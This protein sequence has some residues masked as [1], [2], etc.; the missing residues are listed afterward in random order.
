MNS[1]SAGWVRGL[2]NLHAWSRLSEPPPSRECLPHRA[3]LWDPPAAGTKSSKQ[4]GTGGQEASVL[5]P[6]CLQ[7]AVLKAFHEGVK[8]ISLWGNEA[9]HCTDLPEIAVPLPVTKSTPAQGSPG[10]ILQVT[11]EVHSEQIQKC[12]FGCHHQT[13]RKIYFTSANSEGRGTHSQPP[14]PV[15][16]VSVALTHISLLGGELAEGKHK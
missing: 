10:H 16:K 3:A 14:H 8:H 11:T 5:L 15:R 1:E 13:S 2:C 7:G 9:S 4:S 12:P 6:Q